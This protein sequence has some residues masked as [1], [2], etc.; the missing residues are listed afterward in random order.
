MLAIAIT[1]PATHPAKQKNN[2]RSLTRIGILRLPFT[3]LC[4]AM[5]TFQ[6]A[7]IR[8]VLDFGTS[9]IISRRLPG[10]ICQHVEIVALAVPP[11]EYYDGPRLDA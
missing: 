3:P 1:I 9:R 8:S 4:R 2:K 11:I 6:S 7:A 10:A 5:L